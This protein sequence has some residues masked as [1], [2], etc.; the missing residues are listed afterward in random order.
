MTLR[1]FKY[2]AIFA[3]VMYSRLYNTKQSEV[4]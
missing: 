4:N 1:L 2:P 3:D